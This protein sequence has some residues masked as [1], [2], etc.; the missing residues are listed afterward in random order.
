MRTLKNLSAIIFLILLYSCGNSNNDFDAK[1]SFEAIE[2][3]VSSEASGKILVFNIREGQSMDVNQK[4]GCIDSIQLYLR[5][6]QLIANVRALE[7]RLPET[8]KQLASLEQQIKTAITEKKRIEN[9]LSAD[10]ANQ[11][12]LDDINAQIAFMEKQLDAQKSNLDNTTNGIMNE[13]SAL[14]IQIDQVEDQLAK[15][16][17]INPIKG[18]V[19]VKYVQTNEITSPGKP[20]YKI[21]DIDNMILRAYLTTDQLSKVKIGQ[22]VK[23]FSDSEGD[24]LK[25]YSGVIE[26][27]ASKAEFTPKTIQTRDERANLVYAVKIAVVNDGFLKIGMYGEIKI[28]Q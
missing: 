16:K 5:K 19:L 1:G 12:Q 14:K 21:S 9:L 6:K 28:E 15:C 23:V 13:I 25:E 3:I 26:W 11:K 7:S 22:K 8:G 24:S 17:I 4:V 2:T 18:M 27:I 10:A 20:L